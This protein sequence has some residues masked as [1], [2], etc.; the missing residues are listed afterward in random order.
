MAF[1]AHGKYDFS[2]Q[3]EI[4]IVRSYQAWNFECVKGF[5]QDYQTFVLKQKLKQFGAMVDLRKFEGGTPEAIAYFGEISQ[6]AYDNGQIARAQVIN[7]PLKEYTLKKPTEGKEVFPIQS[8]DD[9]PQ[10]LA[11][12]ESLGLAVN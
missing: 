1:E 10:A 2:V 9:V 8:F 11:W 4:I 7:S 5:F 6:W 12:L 3:G